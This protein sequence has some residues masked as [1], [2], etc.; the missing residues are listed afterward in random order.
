MRQG[1]FTLSLNNFLLR[2][3]NKR[4]AKV[5]ECLFFGNLYVLAFSFLF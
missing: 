4:H 2:M 3:K 1:L 5:F